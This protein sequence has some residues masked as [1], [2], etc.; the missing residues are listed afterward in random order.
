MANKDNPRGLWPVEH[1]CGGQIQPRGYT[2]TTGA[3]VYQGDVLKAVAG[4]TVEASA[5]NDGAIVIGVAAEYKSDSASAG[6]IKVLVYDDPNI[7]FG[8]Q[9]DSGTGVAATDVFSMANHVAGSG[10]S[11]TKLSGH[12]ID[13]SQLAAQGGNQLKVLGIVQEE[14]NDW[15]EHVDLKVIFNEHL[16]KAAVNGI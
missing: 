11:T 13:S 5:A 7:V 3:T 10:S 12:E 4:G 6:G 1:L 14:G 15:G 2:L 9:A 16:L 8:V